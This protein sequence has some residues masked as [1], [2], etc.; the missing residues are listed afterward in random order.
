VIDVTSTRR[1]PGDERSEGCGADAADHRGVG[2]MAEESVSL[3]LAVA[4]AYVPIAIRARSVMRGN[5]GAG[6]GESV[7]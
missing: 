6:R 2:S 5:R 3:L 1:R 7:R 4:L